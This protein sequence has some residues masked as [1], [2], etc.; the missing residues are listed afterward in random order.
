[1][2]VAL[3]DHRAIR[4][5]KLVIA[6]LACWLRRQDRHIP[7]ELYYDNSCSLS[8]STYSVL[9]TVLNLWHEF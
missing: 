2:Y 9:C 5:V 3:G 7:D 8:L 1:M 4:D 6:E